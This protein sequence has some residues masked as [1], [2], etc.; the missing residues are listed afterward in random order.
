MASNNQSLV[1]VTGLS[2]GGKTTA[3]HAL[4]DLGYYCVDNLPAALLP[5]FARHL[6]S[7]PDLYSRVSLGIDARARGSE[8]ENI[9]DWLEQLTAS[10]LANQMLFLTADTA[11][12][13]QRFSETRRRHPLTQ[14]QRALPEA[15]DRE[16]T[17]LKPLQIRADWVLDTSKINIHELR[18]QVWKCIDADEQSMTVILE[19][20][21]FKLGVPQEADFLFDAR[22]LPNPYWIA[23]LRNLSGLDAPVRQWLEQDK[24]VERFYSDILQL[25]Q[26]W[27]PDIRKS[28]RSYVTIGIG[29]TG[30]RHRSVYLA[31]RLTSSLRQQ[32][33][34]VVVH[35]REIER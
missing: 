10:G 17:L 29:C 24:S 33:H 8:L 4:E 12:I 26:Q 20:F 9:P 22:H 27:L 28:Q 1:L 5:D 6:M 32:F 3:L 30:G 16:R 13:I 15:I 14:D 31:D 23:E 34:P 11:T 21:A 19:S 2:G 35:H 25:L 18:H 7:K